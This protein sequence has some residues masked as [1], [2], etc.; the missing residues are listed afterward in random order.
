MIQK[1]ESENNR[2]TGETILHYSDGLSCHF[3]ML[4]LFR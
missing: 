3:L 2:K 1:I 4:I